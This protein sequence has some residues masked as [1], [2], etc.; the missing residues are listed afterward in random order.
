MHPALYSLGLQ[1]KTEF[2][3]PLPLRMHADW[4]TSP[5][6]FLNNPKVFNTIPDNLGSSNFTWDV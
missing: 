4:S 1:S 3:Q 2:T 5:K 6:K